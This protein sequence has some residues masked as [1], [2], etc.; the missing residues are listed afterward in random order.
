MDGR[1]ESGDTSGARPVTR[2]ALLGGAGAALAAGATGSAAGQESGMGDEQVPDVADWFSGDAKGGETTAFTGVADER[3]ESSVTVEVGADG[4]GGSFAY[5]PTALWVDPGT[6]VTFEWASDTHNV[7]VETQPDGADWAGH[8]PVE[9]TG[10]AFEHT[11]EAGGVYDYY[12]QPH[13]GLGMKGTV[14]VGDDVPM[15]SPGGTDRGFS[16]PGGDL[17]VAFLGLLFG[18]VGLAAA[19]VLAGETR[20][21]ITPEEGPTSAWTTAV[22]AVGVGLVVLAV[23]VVRLLG[24]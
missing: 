21:A 5:A 22:A 15:T 12:C 17:G 7:V 6:T 11:F 4:N 14:V 13:L 19:L 20:A 8:E 23:V 1:S 3:G 2:R 24:A 18:T 16:F 10:F 9:D